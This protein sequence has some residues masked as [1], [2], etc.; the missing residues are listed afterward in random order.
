MLSKNLG[1]HGSN[2]PV[3]LHPFFCCFDCLCW[4]FLF[5]TALPFVAICGNMPIS[6]QNPVADVFL[7]LLSFSML[8]EKSP[9]MGANFLY[10]NVSRNPFDLER[11]YSV[12]PNIW[13]K[14]KRY[15]KNIFRDSKNQLFSI[16]VKG[17]GYQKFSD[18]PTVRF[19]SKKQLDILLSF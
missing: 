9:G 2:S 14:F 1:F 15:F 16:Q 19:F 8:S 10:C 12:F 13:A 18:Y 6:F 3:L 7:L 5:Y 11:I 17:G 4:S